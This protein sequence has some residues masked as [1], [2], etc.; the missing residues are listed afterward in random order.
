[1][2]IENI[3]K[4]PFDKILV[5]GGNGFLGKF[6]TNELKKNNANFFV[7]R[8]VDFDLTRETE[9]VRLLQTTRPDLIIHL[10]AA[11]GGI[12]ETKQNPGKFFYDNLMMGTMLMEQAR[13]FGVAKFVAVGSVSAYPK[14]T[15]VPFCEE[16]LWD[17]YPEK[18]MAPYGLAKKMLL[19]QSESYREQYGFNSI[20]LLLTN[21]YGEYDNFD[22]TTAQVVPAVIAKCCAAKARKDQFVEIWGTGAATREFLYAG[23]AAVA[24]LR[25]AAFY[26]ESNAVNVGTGIETK[27]TDLV[28]LIA[29]IVGFNGKVRW[30][31][32]EPDG[33]LRRCLNVSKAREKFGFTA[34]T[35]LGDGLRRTINWYLKNVFKAGI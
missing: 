9:V 13:R 31:I 17:G 16:D 19:V 28:R 25:A 14:S 35:A 5:T 20:Y 1:M 7:S 11:V 12:R 26:N 10:A 30:N 21:L 34:D 3:L 8:R 32:N 27:I 15:P 24:I 4:L 6:V 22:L 2:T 18:T 29:D 23:D 33:D